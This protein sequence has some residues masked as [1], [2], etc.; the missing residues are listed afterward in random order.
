MRNLVNYLIE[1]LDSN[2]HYVSVDVSDKIA[3]F[4]SDFARFS[5]HSNQELA[6]EILDDMVIYTHR[7][8][9]NIVY[10]AAST[11]QN[12]DVYLKIEKP[13]IDFK[14]VS[15]YGAYI[16]HLKEAVLDEDGKVLEPDKPYLMYSINFYQ[17]EDSFERE[18]RGFDATGFM[19]K[20]NKYIYEI[21][22]KDMDNYIVTTHEN[23]ILA[24]TR[25]GDIIRDIKSDIDKK[26]PLD[27]QNELISYSIYSSD[28]MVA[29]VLDKNKDAS[30]Q[31]NVKCTYVYD[32]NKDLI[33][34]EFEGNFVI[35]RIFFPKEKYFTDKSYIWLTEST[36]D[37]EKR[38]SELEGKDEEEIIS[39]LME[40]EAE[41]FT[42]GITPLNLLDKE[43]K[44]KYIPISKNVN[45]MGGIVDGLDIM[46]TVHSN[47]DE[48]GFI[49]R[50]YECK[51]GQIFYEDVSTTALPANIMV[52]ER[53]G[54]LSFK[55]NT[56]KV[57]NIV[58]YFLEKGDV[59]KYSVV[60][61]N[62]NSQQEFDEAIQDMTNHLI[63]IN[64]DKEIAE[65]E[66]ASLLAYKDY[67]EEMEDSHTTV[68]KSNHYVNLT[69]GELYG[70]ISKLS[71][72]AEAK[73]I[74]ETYAGKNV[75]F[76]M[77]HKI[78]GSMEDIY[79]EEE[80]K[81]KADMEVFEELSR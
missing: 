12:S 51:D 80:A 18:V 27:P 31:N 28:L 20:N 14:L 41:S 10:I 70:E 48:G 36:F 50:F 34:N 74:V 37:Y 19:E 75:E 6:K 53:T 32:V 49:F 66:V 54:T 1:K 25:E 81:Y 3:K 57:Q 78:K 68:L 21:Y 7:D 38:K 30:L 64:D 11:L 26:I 23:E 63:K 71:F 15:G 69:T 77:R 76:K 60:Q 33:I 67:L 17:P 16:Y 52:N 42:S 29:R 79:R 61:I 43:E 56:S 45:D 47:K 2:C 39:I 35:N 13:I 58:T 4:D 65:D 22:M 40:E 44:N 5:G 55:F 46:Y 59:L 9:D 24:I 62:N 73:I 72:G 8:K